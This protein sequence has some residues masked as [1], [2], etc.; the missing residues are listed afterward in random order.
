MKRSFIVFLFIINCVLAFSQDK[1]ALWK[2]YFKVGIDGAS[3]FIGRDKSALPNDL[4]NTLQRITLKD[5]PQ[6]EYKLTRVVSDNSGILSAFAMQKIKITE[7]FY[8]TNKSLINK[9][10]I[11]V[12]TNNVENDLD[13]MA[14]VNDIMNGYAQKIEA[15]RVQEHW[16]GPPSVKGRFIWLW[17]SKNLIVTMSPSDSFWVWDNSPLYLTIIKQQ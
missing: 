5:D 14:A 8:I 17:K 10:E 11:E 7:N 15:P 2:E 4:A 13:I 9:W 6:H 12:L 16:Y 1:I 3:N